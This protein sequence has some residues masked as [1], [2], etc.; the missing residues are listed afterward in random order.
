MPEKLTS[1]QEAFARHYAQHG[2]ASSAYRHAY[3]HARMS[4]KSIWENASRVLKNSK[5]TA[6]VHELQKRAEQIAAKRFD[7]SAEAILQGLAEIAHTSGD[8][9]ARIAAFQALGRFTGLDKVAVNRGL[10][11]D[12]FVG[13]T[14]FLTFDENGDLV[15]SPDAKRKMN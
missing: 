15:T 5:V 4:D 12:D 3:D 7:T 6:R 2:C 9:R 10:T 11:V 13:H 8:E 1:K 14:G